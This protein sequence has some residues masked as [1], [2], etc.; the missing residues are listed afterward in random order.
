MLL[1]VGSVVACATDDPVVGTWDQIDSSGHVIAA[2]AA[3]F[4]G[5]G[6]WNTAAGAQ[7]HRK[8]TADGYFIDGVDLVG[9]AVTADARYFVFEAIARYDANLGYCPG[10]WLGAPL[11]G[12]LS[13][14][15]WMKSCQGPYMGAQVRRSQTTR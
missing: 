6:T 14:S 7:G 3:D 2:A 5:D 13:G 15:T 1:S 11:L 8:R 10:W 9:A 12:G 4:Y